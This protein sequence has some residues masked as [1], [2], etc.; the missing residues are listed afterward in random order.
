MHFQ[1]TH[2]LIEVNGS[3]PKTACIQS[4][5]TQTEL[6]RCEPSLT[7]ILTNQCKKRSVY[8]PIYRLLWSGH[9]TCLPFVSQ[10]CYRGEEGAL[11]TDETWEPMDD[12]TAP[13]NSRHS[14]ALFS[15][16]QLVLA[17]TGEIT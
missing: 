4:C 13:S 11:T 5:C 8:L 17:A 15:P 1:K 12:V 7:P 16:L 10:W 9:V 3:S 14:S 6:H 2:G